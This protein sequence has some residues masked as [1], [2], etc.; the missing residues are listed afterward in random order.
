MLWQAW[1]RTHS[2]GLDPSAD[3]GSVSILGLLQRG[4]RSLRYSEVRVSS[5]EVI[6]CLSE[7]STGSL[8]VPPRDCQSK[9]RNFSMTHT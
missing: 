5:S 8:R 6:G 1:Q 7:N 9:E 2:R 4:Q 3:V